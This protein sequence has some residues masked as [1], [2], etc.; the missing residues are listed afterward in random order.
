V[1]CGVE[2]ESLSLKGAVRLPR[3]TV[4]GTFLNMHEHEPVESF[5]DAV[6]AIRST[7]AG[8]PETAY[9]PAVANLLDAVGKTLRP[10]VLCVPHPARGKAGIPD[11]GLF[12]QAKS[13]RSEQPEWVAAVTPERGVVEVKPTGH[14]MAKLPASKQV[15]EDY[16]PVYGL[17]LASNL[18]QWRLVDDTGAVRE[19][20]DLAADEAGF[21]ALL[22]GR[23]S[24]AVLT[25]FAEFLKRCLL[26][27]APL[28]KPA[29]VAFFLASY[30]RD[31]LA[32]LDEHATLP[33]L[34]ALR[35]AIE[36]TLGVEFDA[37]DGEHLF[38]STLVQTL[39]YGLFSAWVAHV[40]ENSGRFDW[41][42]AQWSLHVPVAQFLFGQIASPNA[43]RGLDL[44]SLLDAAQ[45]TL[46]RV[47]R[48]A[49]FRDFEDAHAIQYF[50]EPFLEFFDPVLR[51]EL[52]VWYTPPEI[53][54]YMV[55]RVDRVLR[56]ELDIADGLADERVWVLDP[57]CG[58][59]SFVV[60]VLRRIHTTLQDKGLGDLLAERLKR[61]ACTRIVGFEIMTAPFIIAHWQ[62][63]EALRHVQ[64]PLAVGERAAVYLTNAL[65]GWD[66]AEEAGSLETVFEALAQERAAA[67]AVKRD[68]LILVVLGNP[69]YNA[70]AGVSPASEGGLVEPYKV[71]L[72]NKWNIRK[73]NLD[74]LYVRFYRIAERRIAER[75]GKGMVCFIS[76]YSWL[77]GASYTVMRQSLLRN[78]DR[79]W[80]E[81]MHGDRTVTEYG[82]DGRS[83]ETI[84][85]TKNFSVGI[86]QGVATALLLR[87]GKERAA[88]WRFRDD[89]KDSDAVSRRARLVASL[90][91]GGASF[92]DRYQILVPTEANRFSLRPGA[93]AADCYSS[94][95]SLETLAQAAPIPGLL[96]KRG[97]GLI[98][99]DRAALD[100]RMRAYL[101][102]AREFDQVRSINP[103]LAAD[104]S[105]YTA[106]KARLK[107]LEEGLMEHHLKR[108][109]LLAF[110]MRWAYATPIPTVWNRVRP[111]L[112][113]ILP[114]ARG[115]LVLRR[116]RLAE[117]EGFPAYWTAC[118]GDDYVLHK[119]AF[120][121]PVVENLSGAARPNLSDAT[122]MY[123]STL[124]VATDAEGAAQVWWHALAT[125]YSPAYLN[126]NA[127]GI[128]HGWPH[129]PLPNSAGLLRTSA[130]LGEQV[131][132]LLD[133]DTPVPGITTGAIRA[134]LATIA[135]PTTAPGA[136]RDWKLTGWGSRS[137]KGVTMPGRGRTDSRDYSAAE[138]A[139]AAHA[140]LLG[141]KTRDVWI[142]GASFWRNIPEAVWNLHIGGYQVLKKWLSYRDH[143]ILDRALTEAE[144]EHIQA[145]ARRVAAL[146]LLGP[147][148]DASHRACA[149]AH[150]PLPGA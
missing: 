78:F 109:C 75:T 48:A 73:F 150:V 29:D 113:H 40:R 105:G 99:W 11:F 24:K 57:C 60:E 122:R 45:D 72:I 121:V 141:D 12:E 58:T 66:R 84:F 98:G 55:E 118:L 120:F 5:L 92:D 1:L 70:Y 74:D 56:S 106:K 131:A 142:N 4:P 21:H 146:L 64:A 8:T 59:G 16:L 46:E 125:C 94:W 108:Y 136:Q 129:V 115:F 49:F 38:R 37:K 71:G 76:N 86:R 20:F 123:L 42:A 111:P 15:K 82:P 9:Y 7:R 10:R 63:G 95:P 69:P 134:E 33:A 54:R 96:E 107:L 144:V 147:A 132:G 140:G 31:A 100:A 25:G 133:P 112:L 143:S 62:V 68:Q 104:R 126:E 39:F 35:Q 81:N 101:D 17:L 67:G 116:Q 19:Q 14:D 32:R 139:T 34:A 83:S 26:A 88:V 27:R 13:R 97:G 52:G 124:G 128:R 6:G 18:W 90:E 43:L 51:K 23:R 110:D 2:S 145:T 119:H 135:V 41:R 47:D 103:A 93:A 117:P 36:K 102:P 138:V 79:A 28:G 89:I 61:A 91:E 22:H 87:T 85:A 44:V 30:A 114:K 80:I 65:T 137:D 127:E 3:L 148:L 149:A 130:A 77:S 53:V 50:Y